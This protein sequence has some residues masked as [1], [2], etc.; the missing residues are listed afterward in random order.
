MNC[1]LQQHPFHRLQDSHISS[2]DRKHLSQVNAAKNDKGIFRR[3]VGDENHFVVSLS[4]FRR[5]KCFL[6]LLS[7][8][9]IFYCNTHIPSPIAVVKYND[10]NNC[11]CDFITN[12]SIANFIF[13]HKIPSMRFHRQIFRCKVC[14][15]S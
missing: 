4:Q 15:L 12:L 1:S 5:Q 10:K 8:E 7:L 13:H 2:D 9:K 3:K 6:L 11:H 14:L